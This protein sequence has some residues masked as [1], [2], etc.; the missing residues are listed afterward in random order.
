MGD[1]PFMKTVMKSFWRCFL[2]ARWAAESFFFGLAMLARFNGKD[3]GDLSAW[4]RIA[5]HSS[6]W[7]SFLFVRVVPIVHRA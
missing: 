1:L 6:R 2:A 4:L 7:N 3:Q 5:A